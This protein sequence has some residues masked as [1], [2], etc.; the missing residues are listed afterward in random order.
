MN[1]FP[2]S[3]AMDTRP[4]QGEPKGEE[5]V[6]GVR[7]DVKTLQQLS[8]SGKAAQDH[9]NR[10]KDEKA[11]RMLLDAVQQGIERENQQSSSR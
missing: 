10:N 7:G 1:F 3:S 6:I 8:S 11:K 9:R 5:A 2:R 4:K